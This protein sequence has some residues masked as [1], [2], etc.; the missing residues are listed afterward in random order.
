[1]STAQLEA[2]ATAFGPAVA[3]SCRECGARIPLGPHYVCVECFGPLE[4]AY[5][6]HQAGRP[7]VTR[8]LIE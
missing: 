3:L 7:A 8:E 2:P 4:V 5:D 1:M 6:F